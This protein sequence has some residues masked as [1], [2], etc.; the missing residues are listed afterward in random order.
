M[1]PD[2]SRIRE[3]GHTEDL[4]YE[5]KNEDQR[6]LAAPTSCAAKAALLVVGRSPKNL[7]GPVHL[8]DYL[9]ETAQVENSQGNV[10]IF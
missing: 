6:Q 4:L 9:L 1:A 3:L 5:G 8:L 10:M 7:Q 2:E